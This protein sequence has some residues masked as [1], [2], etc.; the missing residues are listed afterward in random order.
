MKQ[1]DKN[2]QKNATN[3]SAWMLSKCDFLMSLFMEFLEIN[4]MFIQQVI[5]KEKKFLFMQ[6]KIV[7]YTLKSNAFLAQK[8][9]FP[10]T[11]T[12]YLFIYFR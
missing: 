5:A 12:T 4:L 7:S 8:M 6:N 11:T 9:H 1:C 3:R 10:N 2:I